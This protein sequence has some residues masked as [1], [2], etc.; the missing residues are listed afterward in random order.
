[1][2]GIDPLRVEVGDVVEDVWDDLAPHEAK[3]SSC[4]CSFL[5][6]VGT[7]TSTTEGKDLLRVIA[8]DLNRGDVVRRIH[9]R[10][11]EGECHCDLYFD[12]ERVE[13]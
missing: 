2:K 7:S 1:M 5:V 4:H 13:R 3:E 6:K 9:S 8:H 11:D 10:E 12:V